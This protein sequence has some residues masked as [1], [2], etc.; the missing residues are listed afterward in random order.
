MVYRMLTNRAVDRD[1][2]CGRWS[3]IVRSLKPNRA[4][5][6]FALT[7]STDEGIVRS[8]DSNLVTLHKNLQQKQTD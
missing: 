8:F 7:S 3:S 2:L 6:F 5:D 1:K 4:V